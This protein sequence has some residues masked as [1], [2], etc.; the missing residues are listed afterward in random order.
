MSVFDTVGTVF[1]VL[2]VSINAKKVSVS[3][4]TIPLSKQINTGISKMVKTKIIFFV[5]LLSL[6]SIIFAHHK[7]TSKVHK[8]RREHRDYGITCDNLQNFDL[9]Q[10]VNEWVGTPYRMGGTSKKGIDCSGFTRMLYREAYCTDLL[11]SSRDMISQITQVKDKSELKE[12][13]LLF[14]K[15]YRH[16]VSHVGVYL[17]DG[18]FVHASTQNG[19]E[20]ASLSM[21]YYQKTFFKAGRIQGVN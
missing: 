8:T 3:K 11:R 1:F 6:P 13:D 21:P 12:G 18:Y 15:I 16:R 14:F 5:V 4:K 9:A 19:V 10:L 20:I 17:K 7:H 2:Y